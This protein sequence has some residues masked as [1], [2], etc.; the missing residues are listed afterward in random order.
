ME[1]YTFTFT[2]RGHVVTYTIMAQNKRVANRLARERERLWRL[3]IDATMK[4]QSSWS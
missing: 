3:A 2:Y 1:T 4:E